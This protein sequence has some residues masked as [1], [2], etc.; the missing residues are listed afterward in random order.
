MSLSPLQGLRQHPCIGPWGLAPHAAV[1]VR[2][3]GA[4]SRACID[5]HLAGHWQGKGRGRSCSPDQLAAGGGSQPIL[6]DV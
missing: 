1:D 5:G 4:Q 6:S 3:E 2:D